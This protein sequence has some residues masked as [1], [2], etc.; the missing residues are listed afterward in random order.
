MPLIDPIPEKSIDMLKNVLATFD[1]EFSKAWTATF[2][3]KLG[4]SNQ[5]PGDPALIRDLLDLMA[6][7]KA[8]FTQ[9]FRGLGNLIQAKTM[10]AGSPMRA[11]FTD[12]GPFAAW[13]AGVVLCG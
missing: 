1:D 11:L 9:T 4:L 7:N 6:S 13:V 8:D 3:A 12:P 5:N 10:P 2:R